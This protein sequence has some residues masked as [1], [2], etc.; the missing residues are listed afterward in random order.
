MLY[1]AIELLLLRLLPGTSVSVVLRAGAL[2]RR[3]A[4]ELP[5]HATRPRSSE[6]H[7]R[8]ESSVAAVEAL[9]A[10]SRML[11]VKFGNSAFRR[12]QVQPGDQQS[13]FSMPMQTQ[14]FELLIRNGVQT[15]LPVSRPVRSLPQLSQSLDHTLKSFNL[16]RSRLQQ[17]LFY[18]FAYVAYWLETSERGG[19]SQR[20][21][22][23]TT[24]PVQHFIA[25]LADL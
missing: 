3:N 14:N 8:F 18:E 10:K 21:D 6:R 25:V 19:T 7:L 17:P 1:V 9:T 13:V 4:K 16:E 22:H 11:Q 2:R 23:S 15:L 24:Q 5:R 12:R 20:I